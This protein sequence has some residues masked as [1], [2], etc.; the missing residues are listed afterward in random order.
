MALRFAVGL[1]F[2]VG[3]YIGWEGTWTS[4]FGDA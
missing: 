2:V 3:L 4:E 1:R